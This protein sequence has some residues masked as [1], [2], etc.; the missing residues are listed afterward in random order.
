MSYSITSDFGEK[1]A[2]LLLALLKKHNCEDFGAISGFFETD[3]FWCCPCCHRQKSEIAR[4]DKNGNLFCQFVWHHDHMGDLSDR[5]PFHREGLT[6][7]EARPLDSV[8]NNFKRFD[9]ILICG[10]CNV[11][12]GNAKRAIGAPSAFSFTPYEISTFIIVRENQGHALDKD[13]AAEAYRHA[14]PSLEVY[15]ATLRDL[16]KHERD[17]SSFEQIGGAAWRV[18]KQ[19]NDRRKKEDSK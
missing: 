7:Q 8:R 15:R 18:L 17:P 12:D 14:S 3:E 9:D 4:R 1:N 2:R 13:K 11:I 6:W 19:A 10:D 16:P 5:F